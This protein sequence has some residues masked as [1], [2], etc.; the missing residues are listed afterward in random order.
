MGIEA[1][2]YR[3]VS[4]LA[5]LSLLLPAHAGACPWA[6]A[7]VV[8]DTRKREARR[9]LGGRKGARYQRGAVP[10]AGHEAFHAA[11]GDE[12]VSAP[13]TPCISSEM[14]DN[15]EHLA[16]PKKSRL[17][18][19]PSDP[20]GEDHM[21]L[22]RKLRRSVYLGFFLSEQGSEGSV[23]EAQ[24]FV[25]ET[26]EATKSGAVL[27]FMRVVGKAEN[28]YRCNIVS[29]PNQRYLYVYMRQDSATNDRAML[30]FHA[31]AGIQGMY[32]CGSG[33]MLSTDRKTGAKRLQWVAIV[34]VGDNDDEM[35]CGCDDERR[36]PAIQRELESAARSGHDNKVDRRLVSSD[37]VR[38]ADEAVLAHLA[39]P[40]PRPEEWRLDIDCLKERQDEL[41][42]DV[43]GDGSLAGGLRRCWEAREAG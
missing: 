26:A 41:F 24:H 40:L 20:K 12:L 28:R 25:V 21:A 10:A 33:A 1:V 15:L 31:D 30:M 42:H 16:G 14:L 7:A 9:V 22:I 17:P 6:L 18:D 13:V 37:E 32:T 29:P 39:R 27:A 43:L 34:R 38:A 19:G 11:C 35:T 36:M 3:R 4:E 23:P 8:P 5:R 2:L